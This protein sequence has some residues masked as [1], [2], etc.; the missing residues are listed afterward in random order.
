MSERF[1]TTPAHRV[2]SM[3]RN[4]YTVEEI[5]EAVDMDEVEVRGLLRTYNPSYNRWGR[6][7]QYEP[8]RIKMRKLALLYVAFTMN[9]GFDF[10]MA[11]GITTR[12]A[13][14]RLLK[15]IGAVPVFPSR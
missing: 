7:V 6:T 15:K 1:I 10:Y 2:Q 14:R 9:Q 11:Y 12:Q 13:K 3:Q 4:G 8:V 5:A